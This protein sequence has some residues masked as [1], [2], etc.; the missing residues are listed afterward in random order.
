MILSENYAN[1]FGILGD[2][3]NNRETV[4]D[5]EI[6]WSFI[7][8]YSIKHK[9][10]GAFYTQCKNIIPKEYVNKFRI[11]SLMQSKDFETKKNAVSDIEKKFTEN[12]IQFFIVKG[13]EVANYY[14]VPFTRSMGDIDV[15]VK[16]E[17]KEKANK[18]LLELGFENSTIYFNEWQY[19][20]GIVKLE[21]HD[22]IQYEEFTKN[23]ESVKYTETAWEHIN[24]LPDSTN[25]KLDWNFHFIFLLLHLHKHFLNGGAGV[26]LFIDLVAVAQK[27]DLD[28]KYIS[29]VLQS[30]NFSGF[31]SICLGLCSKWFDYTFPLQA[32]LSDDF[33]IKSSETVMENGVFGELQ[34]GVE[35]SVCNVIG[36]KGRFSA[37][38][39]R[40]FP[41]LKL[42]KTDLRYKYLKYLP[43]LLPFAWFH[44]AVAAVK[45]GYLNS[46]LKTVKVFF[47][48]KEKI[49]DRENFLSEWKA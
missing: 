20:R 28:W 45:D 24:T 9:L 6:D 19:T 29:E 34:Q 30:F 4:L 27:N 7:L 40:Y 17:D 21:L 15:V 5:K 8:E 25:V 33:L 13:I 23:K 22:H 32:E 38:L 49:N 37:M 1:F 3:L 42:M 12:N 35:N 10:E 41:P 46:E 44:R 16:T 26:R 47:S 43:F 31:A 2:Y 48:K 36:E 39:S 14:P 11:A 18:L